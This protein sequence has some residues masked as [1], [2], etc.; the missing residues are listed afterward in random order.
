VIWLSAQ[1]LDNEGIAQ[2]LGITEATVNSHWRTIDT[3]RGLT[4][5]QDRG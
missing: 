2:A 5:K 3:P 1:G 4:R